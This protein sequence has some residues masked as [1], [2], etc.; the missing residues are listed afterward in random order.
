MK[1]KI[2]IVLIA[3]A[4]IV[5]AVFTWR[6]AYS[7]RKSNDNLPTLTMISEMSEADVNSLLI[8]YRIIQLR[9]VWGDPTHSQAN[10]DTWQIGDI[11]LIVNYKNNGKVAI[12]GLKNADGTS[13]GEPLPE[14]QP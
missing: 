14:P 8:G 4:V 1:K 13:V 9:E 11:S 7:L 10:K 6:I 3:A 5:L 12:C 2:T